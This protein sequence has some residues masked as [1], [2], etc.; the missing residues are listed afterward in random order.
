MSTNSQG[1]VDL[2]SEP[3]EVEE[4]RAGRISTSSLKMKRTAERLNTAIE[5][6]WASFKAAEVD[7]K[8]KR[9][10]GRKDSLR[11][12]EMLENEKKEILRLVKCIGGVLENCLAGNADE[13][14]LCCIGE[15][16]VSFLTP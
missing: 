7:Q 1:I 3:E 10:M 13:N 15:D 11:T 5:N 4:F 2:T 6:S 9:K 16:L 14:A 8:K 12:I